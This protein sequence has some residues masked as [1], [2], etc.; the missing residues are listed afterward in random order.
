METPVATL[1]TATSAS[2]TAA[3]D[4]SVTAPTSVARYSW[5]ASVSAR[6]KKHVITPFRILDDH[7]L[8]EADSQGTPFGNTRFTGA[9]LAVDREAALHFIGGERGARTLGAEQSLR[10]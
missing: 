2:G 3:P 4:G 7:R 10:N 1:T 5:P 8:W 6:Q 9:P